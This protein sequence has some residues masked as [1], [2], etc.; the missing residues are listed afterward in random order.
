MASED[1][2]SENP[3]SEEITS[4]YGA[5]PMAGPRSEILIHS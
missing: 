1:E 5:T 2:R 3:E 4:G